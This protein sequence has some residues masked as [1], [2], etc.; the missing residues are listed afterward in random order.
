MTPGK[1]TIFALALIFLVLIFVSPVVFREI[2]NFITFGQSG[3]GPKISPEELAQKVMDMRAGVKP[4]AGKKF[5]AGDVYSRYPLNFKDEL[6]VNVGAKDGVKPQGAAVWDGNLVGRVKAVGNDFSVVQT[7]FDPGFSLPARIGKAGKEVLLKG[8]V[9]P[10]LT[11]IPKTADIKNGEVVYSASA[12]FDYG[13][14]L[15]VYGQAIGDQNGVFSEAS[16]L[17]SYSPS[18][19]RYLFLEKN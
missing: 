18:E 2:G 16:L 14:P 5:I 13:M 15:G 17:I 11:L 9:E 19:L 12:N 6:L 8:G 4:D 3:A 7:I 10:K 1:A